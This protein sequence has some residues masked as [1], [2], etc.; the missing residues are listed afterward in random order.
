MRLILLRHGMT[1]ANERRL[2]CGAS[3]PGLSPAGRAEL[4][5]LRGEVRYPGMEGCVCIT[6]GMKR[7]DETLELLYGAEP[8]VRMPGLREMD[9]GCFEM[10]SYEELR[11]RDDYQAWILDESGELAPP[12]GES[13]NAFAER[14]RAAAGSIGQDALV[15][16]HGG[17]IAALM[18][19]WFPGQDYNMYQWQPGNGLGY[20]LRFEGGNAA[21]KRIGL[22]ESG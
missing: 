14:V 19:H 8:D 5:R 11:C 22:P 3:D 13:R 2:Y 10:H 6:S 4:L 21:W 7:T 9:F 17:V 16:C 20:E 1:E 15:V 18:Q 12:G